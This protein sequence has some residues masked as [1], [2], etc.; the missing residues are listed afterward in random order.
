MFLIYCD[1]DIDFLVNIKRIGLKFRSL[2]NEEKEIIK[3]LYESVYS[4]RSLIYKFVNSRKQ[5]NSEYRNIYNSVEDEFI[6]DIFDLIRFESYKVTIHK[7][8][9]DLLNKIVVIQIDKKV[10][11]KYIDLRDIHVFV[12]QFINLSELYVREFIP[13]KS[14]F[15]IP[16]KYRKK[17]KELSGCPSIIDL[18]KEIIIKYIFNNLKTET[19][20]SFYVKRNFSNYIEHINI[21]ISKLS[22][23]DIFKYIEMME[24]YYFN[25]HSSYSNIINDVLM[26]EGLVIRKSSNNISK[27]FILK[28]GLIAKESKIDYSNSELKYILEYI[29][30]VRSILVHG[31]INEIFDEY[32]TLT[33]NVPKLK[34]LNNHGLPKMSKY[35]NILYFTERLSYDFVTIVFKYWID[36]FDNLEYIKNN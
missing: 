4:N 2:N 34:K 21:F 36:N 30:N 11:N 9:E 33:Q 18:A 14:D 1:Y 7:N 16:L 32:N 24:M 29:Y 27:E 6:I 3:K 31:S 22:D 8:I 17:Y 26:I 25:N 28:T 23:I 15:K 13:D 20:G 5:K 10:I 12:K 19:Y 35:K